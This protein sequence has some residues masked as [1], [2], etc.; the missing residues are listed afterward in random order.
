[1]MLV[2]TPWVAAPTQ[3]RLPPHVLRFTTQG[4]TAWFI[5]T[6]F[7]GVYEV[8]DEPALSVV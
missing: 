4:L 8:T 6:G 3:V 1:M 5:D 2:S 7:G